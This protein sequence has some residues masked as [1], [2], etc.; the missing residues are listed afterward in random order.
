MNIKVATIQSLF[1]FTVCLIPP[2]LILAI[3]YNLVANFSPAFVQNFSQLVVIKT[4]LNKGIIML[5]SES[6]STNLSIEKLVER[7]ANAWENGNSEK[8]IADFTEDSL[9]IVPGT[10][11]R[12]KSQIQQAAEDY[13]AKFTDT[14]I[15]IKRI[16]FQGATG[17]IEWDW[18]E[19]NQEN[20][21]I[22]H[23][24]DAI[25]FEL[26]EGKIKYWREY[27]DKLS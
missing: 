10:I 22:S 1:R 17:V 2:I 3:I 23:A 26:E 27:I 25:V 12:G 20:G 14:K 15:K 18:I 7:Q 11:L 8:I 21:E 9:F 16:I 4:Y 13:F 6:E 5:S 24:E 19:K